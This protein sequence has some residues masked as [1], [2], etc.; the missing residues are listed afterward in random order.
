MSMYKIFCVTNR[1]LVEGDFS[2]Q[3]ERIAQAGPSGIILREKDL[4]YP[5]YEKLAGQTRA[6]CGQYGV[7][8][9]LHTFTDAARSLEIRSIHLPYPAFDAMGPKDKAWFETVG[10]SVHSVREAESAWQAGASYLT[11]GHIYAT[12]CKKDLPPRG[13]SFLAEVCRSVRI[14]VYAIGGIHP[15]NAKSCI[16]AGAE[17]VCLMSPFMQAKDPKK[18]LESFC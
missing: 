13:L 9:V 14:P 6:I 10:V 16:E 15:Q 3:I 7:P 4:S 17:G 12:D 8:L 2:R 5:A 18:C 1:H 11:A